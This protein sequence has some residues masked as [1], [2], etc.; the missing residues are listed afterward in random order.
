[1]LHEKVCVPCALNRNT[2]SIAKITNLGRVSTEDLNQLYADRIEEKS[3]LCT[4]EMN[5]FIQFADK[6]NL[7]LKRLI[8]L[9]ILCLQHQR[10]YCVRILGKEVLFL[11]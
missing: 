10:K 1:M 3:I 11:C 5:S 6:N 8:F 7:G 4:D 2:L 9:Q